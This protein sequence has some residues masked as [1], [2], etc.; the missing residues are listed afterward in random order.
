MV[1]VR[2]ECTKEHWEHLPDSRKIEMLIGWVV[3]EVGGRRVKG[4]VLSMDTISKIDPKKMEEL[5]KRGIKI[6]PVDAK[7]PATDG[8]L[9]ESPAEKKSQPK[10]TSV[11]VQE[12]AKRM[13][14]ELR[15]IKKDD[16]NSL[17]EAQ[18]AANVSFRQAL[19]TYHGTEEF[20]PES[21]KIVDAFFAE[22]QRQEASK[23][24]W[25]PMPPFNEWLAAVLTQ[26]GGRE[27]L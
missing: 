13:N 9:F 1:G 23:A 25:R 3:V 18:R 24:R 10:E 27:Q 11:S 6:F 2:A 21:K 20:I 5:V 8:E 14:M 12:I 15:G 16:Y 7:I 4:I 26:K 19:Y 17:N 22:I